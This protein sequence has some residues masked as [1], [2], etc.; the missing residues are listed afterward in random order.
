MHRVIKI[1]LLAFLLSLASINP[2]AVES[3]VGLSEKLV[4]EN[5]RLL[6][7]FSS[8]K[9]FE[10]A[11]FTVNNFLRKWS[12]AGASVA[13]A[14]DGKLIFARG[15]GYADTASKTETQPYNQFRIASISKLVTAVAIMKL[16]EE[17]KLSLGG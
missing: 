4:P 5:V 14:K 15:F 3:N 16:S 10:T 17:G 13:I 8:G 11:S 12:I 7:S 9:E 1:S 2:G 6:N